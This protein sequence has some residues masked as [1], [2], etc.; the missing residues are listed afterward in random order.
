MHPPPVPSCGGQAALPAVPVLSLATPPR[1]PACHL[2]IDLVVWQTGRSVG[3]DWAAAAGGHHGGLLRGARK[4]SDPP[5]PAFAPTI[6]EARATRAT[7]RD[8]SNGDR[9]KKFEQ[10]STL[11]DGPFEGPR[12]AAQSAGLG[13]KTAKLKRSLQRSLKPPT[14]GTTYRPQAERGEK[15]ARCRGLGLLERTCSRTSTSS[16]RAR[17]TRRAR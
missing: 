15:R 4:P 13:R 6:V 2:M 1:L 12:V 10:T 14:G 8:V 9:P 16:W 17:R 5:P 3:G 11:T 7:R